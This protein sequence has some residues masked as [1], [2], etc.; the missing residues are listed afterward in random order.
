MKRNSL[1]NCFPGRSTQTAAECSMKHFRLFA[2]LCESVEV[3]RLEMRDS[4]VVPLD[5]QVV[6]SLVRVSKVLLL[7]VLQQA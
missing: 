1:R 6:K 5:V 7:A 4:F 2:L 3:S